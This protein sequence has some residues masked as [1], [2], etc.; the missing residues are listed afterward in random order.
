MRVMAI[1]TIADPQRFFAAVEAG[2]KDMPSGLSVTAMVPSRDRSKAVCVWEADS[3]DAVSSLVE[4][5][6]G[7]SSTNEFFEVDAANAIGLPDRPR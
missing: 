7:D 3:V 6:T 4:E 5:T 1:H 2:M